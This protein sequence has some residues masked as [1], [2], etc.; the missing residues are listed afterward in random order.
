MEEEK[1]TFNQSARAPRRLTKSCLL[2]FLAPVLLSATLY[3]LEPL[4]PAQLPLHELTQ[5]QTAAPRVNS[6]LL[7]GAEF[8]GVGKLVGPE[9]I[10]Y[11]PISQLIYTACSD[12]WIKRVRVNDSVVEDWVFIGGRPLGIAFGLNNEIIVADP[13]KVWYQSIL[14]DPLNPFP[15]L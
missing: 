6:K 12:G 15:Y 8:I 13:F 11:D 10:A 5:P 7:D 1:T 9:D 4:E 3:H 2:L 14:L